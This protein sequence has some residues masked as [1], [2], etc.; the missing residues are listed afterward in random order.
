DKLVTGVQ[1]C[2]LPI[3]ALV[4]GET[5]ELCRAAA[6]KV[7]VEYES[8]PPIFTIEEAIAANSFH[9]QANHIRRGDVDAALTAAPLKLE[10]EISRSEERRV[11]KEWRS[12]G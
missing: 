5:Q 9:T 12:G 8:L 2:A 3:L 7:I 1:T 10:G 4:V 11:G 6:A